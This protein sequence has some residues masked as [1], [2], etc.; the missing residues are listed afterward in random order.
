MVARGVLMV[1][2]ALATGIWGIAPAMVLAGLVIA[3]T[4]VVAYTAAD[5]ITPAHQ[6]TEASTW[7]TATH[8]VGTSLGTATAGWAVVHMSLS[9]PFVASAIFMVVGS[10]IAVW[11]RARLH[12][13]T[14]LR[15]GDGQDDTPPNA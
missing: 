10:V 8:N 9:A 6:H 12:R 14:P 5:Q 7:V 4:F 1:A 11:W 15:P 13:S 2:A 3:P